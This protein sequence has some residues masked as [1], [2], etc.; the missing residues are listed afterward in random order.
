MDYL[1]VRGLVVSP[2]PRCSPKQE[3]LQE[4]LEHLKCERHLAETT[5]KTHRMHVT[6]QLEE[7]GAVPKKALNKLSSEQV[8]ALFANDARDRGLS[9]TGI[10]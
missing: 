6:P 7:L 10:W 5:I 3:L 9:S 8:L 2:S 4:Y 1:L